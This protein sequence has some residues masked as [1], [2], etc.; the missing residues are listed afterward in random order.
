[1]VKEGYSRLLNIVLLGVICFLMLNTRYTDVNTD[2][3]TS[4]RLGTEGD[5]VPHL[6]ED[7]ALGVAPNT[8][9][10]PKTKNERLA[11]IYTWWNLLDR[12]MEKTY[13]LKNKDGV[14]NIGP[15]W[16]YG[17]V[18]RHQME[19][20]TSQLNH[21]QPNG[22]PK[23]Y[24]EIGVNGGHGTAAMLISDPSLQVVSFDLGAYRYSKPV[25]ELLSYAFPG[26][27]KFHVGSSYDE[28]DKGTKGT[29]SKFA[30]LVASGREAPCDV[31]LIDGDHRHLGAYKDILNARKIAACDNI[32]LFDDLNERSG[33]AF[34]QAVNEGLVEVK[35]EYTGG[36]RNRAVN[37]CLRWIGQPGCYNTTDTAF[38][39]ARCVKCLPK[40][41]FA[42][43]KIAN[44]T[45]PG[46]PN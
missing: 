31:I 3:S 43:A 2:L 46:C 34:R 26:R 15:K 7:A 27:V 14:F 39:N 16:M 45:S 38:I 22:R 32:L 9:F 13:L 17:Y 19:V 36:P 30:D 44:P 23:R 37:P 5:E 40:F 20:Y 1:M 28:N 42:T 6:E 24:C 18:R 11:S 29:V 4:R 21:V 33:D 35:R 25:Y 12:L 41:S 8:R 10:I